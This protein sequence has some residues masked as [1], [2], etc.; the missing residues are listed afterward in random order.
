M[1]IIVLPLA[2]GIISKNK[3]KLSEDTEEEGIHNIRHD[4]FV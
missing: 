2:A 3:K 4:I 1:Q